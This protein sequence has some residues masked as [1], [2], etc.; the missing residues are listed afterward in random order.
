MI[1]VGGAATGG[2]GA[3]GVAR[4]AVGG[5]FG[6]TGFGGTSGFR[7]NTMGRFFSGLSNIFGRRTFA[8]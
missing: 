8:G 1:P 4:P 3:I 5:S 2:F 7:T 6:S